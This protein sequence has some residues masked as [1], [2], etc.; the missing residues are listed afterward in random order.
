MKTMKK[1]IASTA[2][3]AMLA[4]SNVN[5]QEYIDE[6]Y[7]YSDGLDATQLTAILPIAV[8]IGAG[9]LIATTSRSSNHSSSSFHA[10]AHASSTSLSNVSGST[11]SLGGS[12][13]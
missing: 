1:I 9:I 13:L 8:L 7:A 4:A 10:H 3:F 5:G 11:L 2:L 12:S 6:G